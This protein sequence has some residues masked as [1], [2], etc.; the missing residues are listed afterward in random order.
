[1]SVLRSKADCIPKSWLNLG[2]MVVIL[3]LL[4]GLHLTMTNHEEAAKLTF[5]DLSLEEG[6]QHVKTM[7]G[8]SA[9]SFMGELSHAGYLDAPVTY[10][11]CEED[12]VVKPELQRKMVERMKEAGAKVDVVN[13]KSGHCPNISQPE[14]VIRAVR[15][16]AG[17]QI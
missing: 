7:S 16:A 14:V 4:Q 10:L 2:G 12:Q 5:S 1:M 8:H 13:V 6:L 17:E 15:R 3:I 11:I 9:M